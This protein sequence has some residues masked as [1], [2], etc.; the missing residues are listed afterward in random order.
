MLQSWGREYNLNFNIQK[1]SL[2]L[3][4]FVLFSK[5]VWPRDCSPGR[6]GSD[7]VR[8]KAVARS[9]ERKRGLRPS[10]WVA[11]VPETTNGGTW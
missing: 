2:F 5:V 6:A 7:V 9:E 1:N 10:L 8:A 11:G 3:R 4:S